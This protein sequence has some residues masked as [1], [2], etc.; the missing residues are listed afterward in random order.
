[1]QGFLDLNKVDP[2]KFPLDRMSIRGASP[3][4]TFPG[5]IYDYMRG[6]PGWCE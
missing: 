3:S 5:N 6:N 2:L 4:P 1:M